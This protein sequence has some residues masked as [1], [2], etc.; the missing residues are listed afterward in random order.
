M[1]VKPH[2]KYHPPVTNHGIPIHPDTLADILARAYETAE[3]EPYGAPHHYAATTVLAH[4]ARLGV[5]V[6]DPVGIGDIAD[7]AGVTR[8]AVEK[9]RTREG[10][11]FPEPAWYIGGRG[12]WD[13]ATILEWGRATGRVRDGDIWA[14]PGQPAPPA[15]A[16][17]TPADTNDGHPKLVDL[18]A[19]LEHSVTEAKAAR[20]QHPQPVPPAAEAGERDAPA[21]AR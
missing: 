1:D 16:E 7:R 11:Q 17:E 2:K 6:P 18:M 19:D 4:L 9:W 14:K 10:L 5:R 3:P 20:A 21:E 15:A 12:A 13:W 8:T